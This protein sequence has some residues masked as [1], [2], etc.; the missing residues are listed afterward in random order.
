MVR[1]RGVV[2]P[3][4]GVLL[5]LAI[6]GSAAALA[7]R[8]PRL[9]A[10]TPEQL[11]AS[12][13]K[14]LDNPVPISGDVASHVDLGL[15]SISGFGGATNPAEIVG[16][17][18]DVRLWVSK[19]GLRIDDLLSFS[20]RSLFVGTSDAWAWDSERFTAYHLGPYPKTA[21]AREPASPM[22][23]A[24]PLEMTRR[25][26]ASIDPTTAVSLAPPRT[27]AGRASYVLRLTP[28]STRTL[29]GAVEIAVDAK[30]RLPLRFSAFARGASKPAIS[31]G[32][33]SVGF[34]RI[35]PSV[36]RFKPPPGASVR[37]TSFPPHRAASEPRSRKA[38]NTS[39]GATQDVRTFG[40]GW[41]SIIAIRVPALP[42]SG[43]GGIDLRKLLPYSGPL[44]SVAFVERGDHAWIVGGLVP[45][46]ALTQIAPQLQ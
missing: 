32:F 39:S 1:R 18:H 26:L 4:I 23:V 11:V 27:V 7:N 42:R 5:A 10:T 31:I 43:R 36:Y 3:G 24:D 46:P 13:I 45:Q 30:R 12:V 35:D 17:D 2:V 19:D 14:A 20:Q 15:P 33:T 41:E 37:Q 21:A 6:A 25:A 44:F 22:P 38:G 29:V 40:A 34:G 28:R 8:T 9:S 16:G